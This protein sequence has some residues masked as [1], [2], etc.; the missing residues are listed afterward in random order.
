MMMGMSM[1]NVVVAVVIGALQSTT[2]GAQTVRPRDGHPPVVRVETRRD[3]VSLGPR[4]RGDTLLWIQPAGTFTP[5]R[6]GPRGLDTLLIMFAPDTLYVLDGDTKR[7]LPP[8]LIPHLRKLR[9]LLL[10]DPDF[11]PRA[12]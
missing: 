6:S 8:N 12:P 10:T 5:A 1:L 9:E 4:M 3:T 7:P 2:S 11:A